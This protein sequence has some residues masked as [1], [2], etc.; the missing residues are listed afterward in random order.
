MV[1]G[2]DRT[3]IGAAYN[4]LRGEMMVA[5]VKINR[6]EKPLH[7]ARTHAQAVVECD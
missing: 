4:L 5:V 6:R 7:V 3:I 2:R 1:H